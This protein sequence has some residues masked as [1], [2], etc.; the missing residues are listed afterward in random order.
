MRAASLEASTAET[1]SAAAALASSRAR[2]AASAFQ[3]RFSLSGSQL[4]LCVGQPCKR[5]GL[6]LLGR[7]QTMAG[8][9]LKEGKMSNFV[10]NE[11]L[12]LA[13]NLFNNLAVVSLATGLIATLF[14]IHY[15]AT[16]IGFENGKPNFGGLPTNALVS[17]LLGVVFCGTFEVAAHSFLL[18]LKE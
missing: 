11:Q 7:V 5:F 17:I 2:A 1:F 3:W 12:K 8:V 6:F 15:S 9:D 14:S 4:R 16:P 13:A 10:H 18:K